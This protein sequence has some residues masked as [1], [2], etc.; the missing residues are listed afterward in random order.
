MAEMLLHQQASSWWHSL[1]CT[2][3]VAMHMMCQA[4][5]AAAG[6]PSCLPCTVQHTGRAPC[7]NSIARSLTCARQRLHAFD[8]DF[9]VCGDVGM[10]DAAAASVSFCVCGW[11]ACAAV[12]GACAWLSCCQHCAACAALSAVCDAAHGCSCVTTHSMT[13]IC[14]LHWH[15][16]MI[17]RCASSSALAAAGPTSLLS[18]FS[19]RCVYQCILTGSHVRLAFQVQQLCSLRDAASGF[20]TSRSCG[21]LLVS[22]GMLVSLSVSAWVQADIRIV[23]V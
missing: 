9:D 15:P 6:A 14:S 1:R 11:H 21:L 17:W 5:C 22:S 20:E 3:A 12:L 4:T 7:T 8:V 23:E 10:W 2:A 16:R 18:D 19:A 13:S